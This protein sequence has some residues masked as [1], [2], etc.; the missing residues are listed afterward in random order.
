MTD[1]QMSLIAAGGVFVVG[2]ISY[3]KWQEYKARKSVERAFSS[4]H[5]DVLMKA[6]ESPAEPTLARHE[7]MFDADLAA[8]AEPVLR[9]PAL[10]EPV[11][12]QDGVAAAPSAGAGAAAAGLRQADAL[13]GAK[14]DT[15]PAQLA[16]NLVD[17]LIDCLIP[18]N[19]EGPLRGDK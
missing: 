17:P 19:S 6:G 14:P 16:E 10:G 3:N 9:E 7:P 1:L 15:P 4:N 18:L 13:P 11:A 12:P 8:G 5:D 2:V